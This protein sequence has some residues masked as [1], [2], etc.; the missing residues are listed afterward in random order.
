M[1][2]LSFWISSQIR[3]LHC[4]KYFTSKEQYICTQTTFFTYRRKCIKTYMSHLAVIFP[5]EMRICMQ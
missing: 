3:F 2:A 4:F 5:T 1:S